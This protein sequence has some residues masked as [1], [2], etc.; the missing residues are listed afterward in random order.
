MQT[1]NRDMNIHNDWEFYTQPETEVNVYLIGRILT[2]YY[3]KFIKLK[4]THKGI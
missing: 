1:N 2:R 4:D 3:Q